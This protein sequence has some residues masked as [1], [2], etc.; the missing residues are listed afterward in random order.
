[1]TGLCIG[2]AGAW[3]IEKQLRDGQLIA[4]CLNINP[5]VGPTRLVADADWHGGWLQSMASNLA[6]ERN[7]DG[8]GRKEGYSTS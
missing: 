1:M 3:L 2:Q 4:L 5:I 8:A 6:G 7:G